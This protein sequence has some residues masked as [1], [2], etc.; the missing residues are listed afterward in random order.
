MSAKIK[1]TQVIKQIIGEKLKDYGFAYQKTEGS[2]RIFIREVQGIKRY[3]DPENE[4]VRQYVSIQESSFSRSLPV[5]L[6]TDAFGY[7]IDEELEELKKYGTGGWISYLDE[8]SYT[9]KLRL[10][11]NL[12]VEYGLDL[13]DKPWIWPDNTTTFC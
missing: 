5:R 1:K 12:T 11:A 4:E 3:Y 10:L 7:G 6:H 9:E 8:E 13:L 2:C